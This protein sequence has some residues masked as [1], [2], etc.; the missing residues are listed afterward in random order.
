MNARDTPAATA[1][2]QPWAID[3]WTPPP[4][5]ISGL[6]ELAEW[7]TEVAWHDGY[8][9]AVADVAERHAELAVT[10][11]AIGHLSYEQR[12]AGRAEEMAAVAREQHVRYGTQEWA[13]LD[14]GATLPSVD[15]HPAPATLSPAVAAA[16]NTPRRAA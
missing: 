13:G 3:A 12:V 11:R 9:A 14:N 7:E 10:W 2:T 15:W 6:L 4:D 8:Q 5:H 1:D 16:D